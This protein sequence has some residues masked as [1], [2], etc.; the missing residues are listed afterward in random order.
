VS[1][2]HLPHALPGVVPD[3][4]E[5]DPQGEREPVAAAGLDRPDDLVDE[6]E[7]A[8]GD[9]HQKRQSRPENPGAAEEC[10]YSNEDRGEAQDQAGQ[11]RVERLGRVMA[12]EP[13]L[14]AV[15][16]DDQRCHEA[17]QAQRREHD[18]SAKPC[19]QRAQVRPHGRRCGP[20]RQGTVV[21]LRVVAGRFGR[22]GGHTASQIELGQT[23][24][25]PPVRRPLPGNGQPV[26]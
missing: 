4:P 12:D 10:H 8:C 9:G 23:V 19:Q 6:P 14:V 13:V 3:E 5:R 18:Q 15:G 21:P 20:C 26:F 25:R 2:W 1:G 7:D 17:E 24:M 22:D 11:R 16:P